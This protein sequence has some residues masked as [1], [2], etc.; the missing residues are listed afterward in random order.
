MYLVFFIQ[1]DDVRLFSI[2]DCLS[3]HARI[4]I[5]I[6]FDTFHHMLLNNGEGLIEA[7]ERASS[8]WDKRSDGI[9]MLD[10][11]DQ[12]EGERHGAHAYAIKDAPFGISWNLQGNLMLTLC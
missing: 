10:Y 1:E 3:I 7:I 12:E 4:K 2:K 11:S 9:L 5:P 6:V 8:T